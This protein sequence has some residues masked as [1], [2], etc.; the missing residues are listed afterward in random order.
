NLNTFGGR[1]RRTKKRKIKK[2]YLVDLQLWSSAGVNIRKSPKRLNIFATVL[3]R[4]ALARQSLT[5]LVN[6]LD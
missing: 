4:Q 6:V 3:T 5:P 1:K 2:N